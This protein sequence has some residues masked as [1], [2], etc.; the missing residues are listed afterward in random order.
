[1]EGTVLGGRY[2][3]IEKI[4]EGGMAQV[5]KAQCTLLDR[6]VAVKVL[7]PQYASDE[8]FV[9][10]FLREAQAA[11][12]LSHPN[13]VNVYDVGRDGETHYIVMEYVPGQTLKQVV[14][15]HAPLSTGQVVSIAEQILLALRHAHERGL[16]HRDVKP[17]NILITTDGR[18]K[19]TD[20]GIARAASGSGITETGI[21]LGSVHY[22]SPEQAKGQAVGVQSDLYSLG[23]LLYEM[24]TGKL[25]FEGDTPIAIAL[26]QIQEEPV[27]PH[28]HN[29]Q[30]PGW[31]EGIILKAMHK[32]PEARY[33]SAEEMLQDLRRWQAVGEDATTVL[34]T[35]SPYRQ[36]QAKKRN[37][38]GSRWLK[39]IAG[40]FIALFALAALAFMLPELLPQVPEVVVPD[41]VG[42]SLEE[43]EQLLAEQKLKAEVRSQVYSSEIAANHVVSQ[44]PAPNRK[45][46]INRTVWLTVSKGPEYLTVP[47]L[48]GQSLEN[49]QRFLRQAGLKVGVVQEQH[50]NDVAAG[51]IMSQNPPSRSRL[52]RNSSVDL[53]VSKGPEPQPQTVTVPAF[54]GK[55]QQEAVLEL[56]RIGLRLGSVTEREAKVPS[57]EVIEQSPLPGAEVPMGTV[58]NLVVSSGTAAEPEEELGYVPGQQ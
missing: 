27:P 19:V 38:K 34:K 50:S 54:V 47:D 42:L 43:A 57:G 49:A 14:V 9:T 56:A 37:P 6:T 1:M 8:E 18:V 39:W 29:P 5:F 24:V 25:P 28:K 41:L 32:D 30:L 12:R 33:L 40:T 31:L 21:V 16:V 7:R 55:K 45:I 35:V 23:V 15:Q 22:F 46:K 17:H 4:G 20:F 53:V 48:V 36:E 44:E 11:A 52:A 26:K 51:V 2:K 10:R 58:V 13:V 3:I